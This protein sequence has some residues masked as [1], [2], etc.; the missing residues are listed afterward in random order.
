VE[1]SAD[2][3]QGIALFDRDVVGDVGVELGPSSR[4]GTG[5]AVPA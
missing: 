2:H 5:E 3:G 1:A 4:D